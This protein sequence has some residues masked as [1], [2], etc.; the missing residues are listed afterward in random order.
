MDCL[1]TIKDHQEYLKSIQ[2]SYALGKK[3]N[4]FKRIEIFKQVLDFPWRSDQKDVLD[5]VLKNSSQY[6]VINGIF[7]CGKTTLLFGIMINLILQQIYKPYEI[8]F[9]SFNVCIKNE[10]KRKLKP[11]GFKGRV[12]VSTFDS[13]IYFICKQYNYPHL[14]L[15]N[16]DGKRR[17]C[18]QLCEQD[19]A[20]P[21]YFQPRLIFIDEVQDLEKNTMTIFQ[22]FF[23]E[24]RIVFAGDVFQSIQKEP[25]ESLLWS[26]LNRDDLSLEKFYMYITPR[27]PRNI[28]SIMKN[29]LTEYYPEFETE[30]SKWKSDNETSEAII[31]WER[32][33][34]YKEI[35]S[36][37]KGHIEEFGEKN[38]MILT[39][40]SAITVKG[41][42]GD[43]ARLRRNFA[44]ENYE[45]NNNHK[46][47]EEDKLFLSTANSSKGLERDY[48]IV[49]LTFPLEKAFSN[50]SD[51]IVMNLITVAITRA[52]KEVY[53]YVPAYIDKFSRILKFFQ[54]CPLPNKEK[55][56][57]GKT[58]DEFEFQDFLEMERSV[59]ELIRQNI[60][61]YDTRIEIKNNIKLYET[62]T[63]FPGEVR[64]KRPV[65]LCEE[66]Q[67]I[68]GIIIENLI[69]STWSG[70]WPDIIDIEVLKNHPMYIHIFGKI[71]NNYE[72]YNK[73]ISKNRKINDEN[74]FNGIYLYS[75]LH[76]AIYNKLFITFPLEKIEIIKKYWTGLKE[77]INSFRPPENVKLKIQVNL[78]M[79]YLT[80]IADA[81]FAN[82]SKINDKEYDELNIWEIKASISTDW[83]DDALTQAFL[84]ALMTGKIWN[85]ITLI[86]PFRNEKANYYFDSKKI[87]SY[88]NL[89]YKDILTWNF[90]CYLAKNYNIRNK[91][92]FKCDDCFFAIT[93][94]LYRK[95]PV[96]LENKK[97]II[98]EPCQHYTCWNCATKLKTCP[99]CREHITCL[100]ENN[101]AQ[102][103]VVEMLSPTKCFV[104]ENTYFKQFLPYDKCSREEKL[105]L[106]SEI[107]FDEKW[108]E[109]YNSKKIWHIGRK[110]NKCYDFF[111]LT[112]R[113][114]NWQKELDYLRNPDLNYYTD[115]DD[116]LVQLFCYLKIIYEKYKFV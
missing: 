6:Y 97:I 70:N 46:K 21:K 86:N 87:M 35:F 75:Q 17:F 61:L 23:P 95:C 48:V 62:D 11:Y 32:F 92:I 18:Y 72:K 114:E 59:T 113:V 111:E 100:K 84:Y 105:C 71:K 108:Y 66:E 109:K 51:D 50:F 7:G 28:L 1:E 8:M 73:Y 2:S 77:K 112:P 85:R 33:Y 41:A 4:Y 3:E 101:I 45:L 54:K 27:V 107:D 13:I 10:I 30:I 74:Q 44:S 15:P 40:S 60:I 16:F 81:I 76:V 80:G 39:F 57:D 78:A 12:Q 56:R 9:V 91:N 55:I 116:A 36:L 89:V 88:R 42:L 47:L 90:N 49:F 94:Y 106:E 37:A 26:L 104:R 58:L 99:I 53:F 83:K 52:K 115:F 43:V 31:Q 22:K 93:K 98:M 96:C 110:L 63:L 64:Y 38:T 20:K 79:P 67:A 24:S 65:M 25:R 69:T 103:C 82:S 34:S 14:D 29:T 102:L 19:L 68:V 5:Q